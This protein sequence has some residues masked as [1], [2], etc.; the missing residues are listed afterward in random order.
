LV[1]AEGR[2][3]VKIRLRT[4]ARP[5][6]QG[7][8]ARRGGYFSLD[9]VVDYQYQLSLGGPV[10][11]EVE[12][13][14]LVAAKIP[15][16]HFRGQWMELDC[17]RMQEAGVGG[18]IGE[19]AAA[20]HPQRLVDGAF[21]LE[22]LLLDVAVLMGH[23]Q[24]VGRRLHAVMHHQQAVAFLGLR[25][26]LGIQGIDGRAEMVGA[27]L[28]QFCGLTFSSTDSPGLCS[29]PYGRRSP[30]APA[31]LAIENRSSLGPARTA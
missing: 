4:S 21:E 15:L 8:A 28:A 1:D 19:L 2:R 22:M 6:T 18:P 30:A 17:E 11:S 20:A 7:P 5:S 16:V 24:V 12:W 14:Q 31:R 27:V 13:Q 25:T 10:V 23:T 3:H 9:T 29:E 26:A